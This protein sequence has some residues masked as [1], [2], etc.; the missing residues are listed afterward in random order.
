M[1]A[2]YD[3]ISTIVS[4][5]DMMKLLFEPLALVFFN[6]YFK[7]MYILSYKLFDVPVHVYNI[8]VKYVKYPDGRHY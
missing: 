2:F 7:Y 8:E 4:F 5:S 6:I 3:Q 1:N